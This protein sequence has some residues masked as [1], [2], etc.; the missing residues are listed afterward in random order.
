MPPVPGTIR[1]SPRCVIRWGVPQPEAGTNSCGAICP[2]TAT[3]TRWS[4]F[5]WIGTFPTLP[6][7]ALGYASAHSARSVRASTP[8]G[9]AYG[10]GRP[11]ANYLCADRHDHPSG[12]DF[13]V[14]HFDPL[15]LPAPESRHRPSVRMDAL[16]R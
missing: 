14:R 6:A 15:D 1:G 9:G 5:V 13:R 8:R 4:L 10:P 3:L 16:A 11:P 12:H 7:L 2:V